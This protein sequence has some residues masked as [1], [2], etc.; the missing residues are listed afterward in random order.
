MSKVLV[1]LANARRLDVHIGD[2]LKRWAGVSLSKLS[3]RESLFAEVEWT[4]AC[5]SVL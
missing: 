1:L 5:F 4:A 3:W 2:V